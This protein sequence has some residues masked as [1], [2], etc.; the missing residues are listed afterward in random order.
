MFPLG[1]S[2]RSRTPPLVNYALIAINVLVFIYELSLQAQGVSRIEARLG[3]TSELEVWIAQWGTVPCRV[4]DTQCARGFPVLDP[5]PGNDPLTLISAMFIHGGLLHI[6]GNMLFLWIFGDN[7]EDT[8]GHVRYLLFYL[9]G[10]IIAGLAHIFS[11][12]NSPIPTVGASGAIAAVLGAYLVTYPFASVKVVIPI[13]IPW[14]TRVPA[15]VMMGLW[16]LSQFIGVGQMTDARGGGG[17]VAYWA[18]IGGFVA[19]MALIWFFRG[20]R[21]SID[22]ERRYA[23][24]RWR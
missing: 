20:R 19:G 1:D 9:L 6:A 24:S 12:P 21:R 5:G 16:F 14:L 8:M 23:E 2:L 18:H 11:D 17:G 15:F 22:L 10:G 13:I 4:V 3:F 7:I